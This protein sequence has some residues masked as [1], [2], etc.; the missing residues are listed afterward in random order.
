M[1]S[2]HAEAHERI[3]RILTGLD[4]VI[5]IKDNI[6]VHGEGKKHDKN[7]QKM[8]SRLEEHNI[9]LQEMSPRFSSGKMVWDDIHKTR[10]VK[11]SGADGA[12]VKMEASYRQEWCQK[13]PPGHSV[14]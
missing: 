1:S 11:G 12:G 6:I 4:S 5:Q 14:L 9:T 8:F 3:R 7:L 13:F 2:T 10:D